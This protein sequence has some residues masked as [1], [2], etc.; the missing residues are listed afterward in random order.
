MVGQSV[1]W[2]VAAAVFLVIGATG[3]VTRAGDDG[4]SRRDRFEAIKA[5]YD[6]QLAAYRTAATEAKTDPDR[7]A[8]AKHRPSLNA[9]GKRFLALAEERPAD[10]VAC[11]ALL[12]IASNYGRHEKV[13]LDG[14]LDLIEKHHLALGSSD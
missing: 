4:P 8:A 9:F 11:D 12:W 14:A 6:K 5:E 13:K 10:E 2:F 7:Q 1:R 3:P